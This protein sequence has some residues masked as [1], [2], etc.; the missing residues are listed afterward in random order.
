MAR[1]KSN[2]DPPGLCEQVIKLSSSEWLDCCFFQKNR[3]S[4]ASPASGQVII[5]GMANAP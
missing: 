3:F 5:A 1:E 4:G 2:F